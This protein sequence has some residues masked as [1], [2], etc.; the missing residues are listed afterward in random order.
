MA[1]IQ[2]KPNTIHP[3]SL[4]GATVDDNMLKALLQGVQSGTQG[5]TQAIAGQ[6]KLA[7]QD[8]DTQT[9]KDSLK[10]LLSQVKPGQHLSMGGASVS[11]PDPMSGLLRKQSLE[12]REKNKL[13][14]LSNTYTKRLEPVMAVN[15]A[16]ED[17]EKLTMQGDKGGVLTNPQ[18]TTPGSGGMSNIIPTSL[19]G[20]AEAAGALPPGSAELRKAIERLK[21][22]YAVLQGGARGLNPSVLK[23][24]GEAMGNI[25]SS[26]PQLI[27][28]GLRALA[29]AAGDR[30]SA[31]Q[32]GTEDEVKARVHAN[33]GRDPGELYK[34]LYKDGSINEQTAATPNTGIMSPE[35]WKA[36]KAAKGT[37]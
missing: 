11:S 37:K 19:S 33:L 25:S 29:K 5:A 21:G 17:I 22:N 20:V 13:S 31:V 34:R 2:P 32:A 27:A 6:Q 14:D 23:F 26:D 3:A 24:E 8:N 28:K 18:A 15:S 36:A 30:V 9:A 12:D 7:Q 35:E 1:L 4:P 16:L 10:A